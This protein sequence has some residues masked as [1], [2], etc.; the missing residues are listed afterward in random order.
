MTALERFWIRVEPEPNTGCWLWSGTLYLGGYGRFTTE[1]RSQQAAHRWAY[2]H[3]RGPIPEGLQLDHLCRVRSCVNPDHLEAVT[4]RVNTL[5]GK[6]RT[7]RNAAK[8]HCV[9]G[10][11]FTPENT[12]L[13][14]AGKRKCRECLKVLHKRRR[15]RRGDERVLIWRVAPAAAVEAGGHAFLTDGTS[16]NRCVF[17]FPDGKQCRRGNG[18]LIHRAPGRPLRNA[19]SPKDPRCER[20]GTERSFHDR[21]DWPHCWEFLA[22][23]GASPS[24]PAASKERT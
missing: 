1:T 5:R 19:D 22:K 3:Y 17:N 2:E 7:A 14:E 8:T 10:H 11:E 18:A 6:G 9:R 12:R 16:R 24:S 4:A 15:L 21:P 13:C 20:C 23:A